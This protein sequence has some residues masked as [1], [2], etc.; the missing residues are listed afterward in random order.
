LLQLAVLQAEVKPCLLIRDRRK[1]HIRTYVVCIENVILDGEGDQDDE[2]LM[3]LFIYDKHEIRIANDSVPEEDTSDR[4][5]NVHIMDA[6][7]ERKQV[8]E[9]PELL[10]RNLNRK[11]ELFAAQ[12]FDK[13]LRPDIERRIALSS[14]T[15]EEEN[16]ESMHTM[17]LP[18][19]FVVAGLDLM[20]TEDER[21]YLLEVNVNPS[22]PEPHTVSPEF[23]SYLL[24]FQSDLLQLVT[25]K[26]AS[27]KSPNS[28]FLSTRSILERKL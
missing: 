8:R 1:F 22:A 24:N 18:H 11:C 3:K 13:H 16:K 27:A 23:Q 2:D 15:L 20:V 28:S 14:S 25:T 26:G 17:V 10:K 19:K 12:V 6:S 9:E 7:A 21:I 5:R 4:D